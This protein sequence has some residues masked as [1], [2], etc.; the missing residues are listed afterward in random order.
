MSADESVPLDRQHVEGDRGK[1]RY[2]YQ[3]INDRNRRFKCPAR[4]AETD[5]AGPEPHHNED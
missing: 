1:C 5:S 3:A 4:R 2:C